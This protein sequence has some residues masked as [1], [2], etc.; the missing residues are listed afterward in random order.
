[1]AFSAGQ[2]NPYERFQD[3]APTRCQT[4]ETFCVIEF[5]LTLAKEQVNR[6]GTKTQRYHWYTQLLDLHTELSI[7]NGLITLLFFGLIVIELSRNVHKK[8][9][10]VL[11]EL[12]MTP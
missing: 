6:C 3:D 7:F 5:R 2:V 11:N 4:Y 8:H 1:M 12:V 9:L 10:F